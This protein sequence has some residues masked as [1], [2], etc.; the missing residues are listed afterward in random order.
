[1][2]K[3]RTAVELPERGADAEDDDE[4][5]DFGAPEVPT[6]TTDDPPAPQNDKSTEDCD[7]KPSGKSFFRKSPSKTCTSPTDK[8]IMCG[9]SV[10]GLAETLVDAEIPLGL[11]PKINDWCGRN[12][13]SKARQ[14]LKESTF[15]SLVEDVGLKELE[16]DRLYEEL[17]EAYGEF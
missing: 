13:I 9:V 11:R 15:N 7:P 12:G 14:L 2:L 8:A 6:R 5:F 4:V 1:M 17:D 16:S 10:K 3:R